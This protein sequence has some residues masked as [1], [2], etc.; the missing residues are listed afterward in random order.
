MEHYKNLTIVGTSHIS[1]ESVKLV[2]R[3]ILDEQPEIV[4]LE[5]DKLRFASLISGKKKKLKLA[6]IKSF[7]LKLFLI[8]FI[9]AW[10]EKKLG[11][12]VGTPPGSEM[13][14]AV[15]TAKK[16]KCDIALI[17][18]D[19]RITLKRLLKN[20]TWR[21]KLKF[22]WDI[23]KGLILRKPIVKFDLRKVPSNKIIETL[24]KK[25]KKDY[26]SFYQVLIEERNVV[27]SQNLYKLMSLNKPIV[28]VIGAGHEKEILRLIKIQA[29]NE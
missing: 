29:K 6:D 13:L 7:G 10:L 20:L 24:L 25:V 11:E 8:N 26:P 5:L 12:L 2:E 14:K 17:D 18:R 28:A 4:A 16:I 22:P 3:I 27:M 9:G 15:Q 19:I 1:P 21:E 23:I